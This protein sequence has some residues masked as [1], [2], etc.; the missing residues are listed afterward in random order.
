MVPEEGAQPGEKSIIGFAAKK[1]L[2]L[3]SPAPRGVHRGFGCFA[4]FANKV[5]SAPLRELDARRMSGE[6]IRGHCPVFPFQVL[7]LVG[8]ALARL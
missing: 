5:K 2:Q 3:Q 1:T 4:D 6:L 8:P 7:S